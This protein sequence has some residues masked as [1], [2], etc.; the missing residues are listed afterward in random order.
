MADDVPEVGK[1]SRRRRNWR[2]NE[3]RASDK[4][5]AKR[6]SDVD[7]RALTRFAEAQGVKVAVLLEPFVTE[8]I[9]QAHEYCEKNGETL[10]SAKA[11]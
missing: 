4:M 2:L 8:L 9:K 3:T 5:V 7:H 1:A 10:E 11:S 6:V